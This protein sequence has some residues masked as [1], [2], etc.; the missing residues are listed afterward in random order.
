MKLIQWL[1]RMDK[2]NKQTKL[3]KPQSRFCFWLSSLW[4]RCCEECVGTCHNPNDVLLYYNNIAFYLLMIDYNGREK[5]SKIKLPTSQQS[6]YRK[7]NMKKTTG[8]ATT[9]SKIVSQN[10]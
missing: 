4:Q 5:K 10:M 9:T 2:Q 3:K 6:H 7:G 1:F 8:Y